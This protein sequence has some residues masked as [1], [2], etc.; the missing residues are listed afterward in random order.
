MSGGRPP[1]IGVGFQKCGSTSLFHLAVAGTGIRG[2]KKALYGGKELHGLPGY[3]RPKAAHRRSYLRQL[4]AGNRA[5][6][7]PNYA[8]K[9]SNLFSLD[10]WFPNVKFLLI[11]RNP[12]DRFF[13][14]LDHTKG[15][16]FVDPGTSDAQAFDA[17][18]SG[19]SNNFWVQSLL[20]YG[21]YLPGLEAAVASFGLDRVYL[22]SLEML[23]EPTQFPEEVARLADFLGADARNFPTKLPLS[24][25]FNGPGTGRIT[26]RQKTPRSESVVD[27][28]RSYY[29]EWF[30][31]KAPD[32]IESYI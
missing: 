16:G 21:R 14:A 18:Y 26:L 11:V 13:S 3:T 4:G 17:S 15:G 5:E 25:Q 9:P 8:Y 32:R 28:L 6:F 19:S 1:F 24:N 27:R 30:D 22:T 20:P 29:S 31:M 10:S 2:P 23:R 12:I 7:T